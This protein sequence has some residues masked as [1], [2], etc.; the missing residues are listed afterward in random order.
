MAGQGHYISDKSIR[1]VVHLLASTEMTVRE[2][3]ERMG[4]SKSAVIT[5]N[6]KFQVRKYDGLRTRWR[7]G[8]I[9]TSPPLMEDIAEQLAQRLMKKKSA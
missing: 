2:I 3:A 7:A 9:Q 8:S 6:R 1:Q 4:Y 5:I